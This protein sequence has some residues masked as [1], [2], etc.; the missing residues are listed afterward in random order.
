MSTEEAIS[1]AFQQVDSREDSQM[2]ASA[3]SITV[4]KDDMHEVETSN[5]T[6]PPF[7]MSNNPSQSQSAS[8]Q[9]SSEIGIEGANYSVSHQKRHCSNTSID[10]VLLPFIIINS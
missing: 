2:L 9:D 10:N 6:H 7:R 4:T 8:S 3:H 5:D 1:D